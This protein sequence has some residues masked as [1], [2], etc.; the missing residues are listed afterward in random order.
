[1]SWL[2]AECYSIDT[3]QI[4]KEIE[5]TKI[6]LLIKI[7]GSKIARRY[8]KLKGPIYAYYSILNSERILAPSIPLASEPALKFGFVSY[9][10]CCA[11]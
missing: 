5:D 11:V 2:F 4:L 6:L 3:R 7:E 1:M 10:I 9:L 8:S